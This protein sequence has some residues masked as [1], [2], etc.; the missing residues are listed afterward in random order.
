MAKA[1]AN[2]TRGSNTL[3][4]VVPPSVLDELRLV[5]STW[6]DDRLAFFD[7]KESGE[8]AAIMAAS[9]RIVAPVPATVAQHETALRAQVA[10][11]ASTPET[12][13]VVTTAIAALASGNEDGAFALEAYM[14]T[15]LDAGYSVADLELAKRWLHTP[16]GHDPAR[17]DFRLFRFKPSPAEWIELCDAARSH[18][19]YML[20]S[21]DRK[22]QLE[23]D[24]RDLLARR[25]ELEAAEAERSTETAIRT[26]ELWGCFEREREQRQ[27][28]TVS[29]ATGLDDATRERLRAIRR[30]RA[31]DPQARARI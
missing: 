30:P 26:S 17:P 10:K 14:Q 1:L 3:P 12:L 6:V 8:L 11:S 29:A 7:A 25:A 22:R 19:R 4:A 28:A 23:A 27:R 13:R 15:T 9:E 24:A 21:L 31:I 5:S 18:H 2:A 16:P 20:L